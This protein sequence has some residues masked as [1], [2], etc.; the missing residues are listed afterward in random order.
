MHALVVFQNTLP[1]RTRFDAA[2]SDI[3][4]ELLD[5]ALTAGDC[6]HCRYILA[7]G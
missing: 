3:A 7:S 5:G 4:R 1:V 2:F 6:W